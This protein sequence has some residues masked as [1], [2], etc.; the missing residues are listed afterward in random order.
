[1]AVP[2]EFI[3][4]LFP[5]VGVLSGPLLIMVPSLILKTPDLIPKADSSPSIYAPS[6]LYVANPAE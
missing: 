6:M 3:P 1:M 4:L 2:D 5:V